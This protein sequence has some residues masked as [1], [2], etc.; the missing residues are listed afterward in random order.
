[1]ARYHA[2]SMGRY[3]QLLCE[4]ALHALDHEVRVEGDEGWEWVMDGDVDPKEEV[5]AAIREISH[6]LFEMT[7][8]ANAIERVSGYKAEDGHALRE[9]G[10]AHME[11]QDEHADDWEWVYECD[12]DLLYDDD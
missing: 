7:A 9:Y 4:D 6:Q 12:E 8:A 1:M 5:A 11:W 2:R 10:R 3:C